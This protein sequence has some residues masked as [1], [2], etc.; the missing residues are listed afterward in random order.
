MCCI[1]RRQETEIAVDK[2]G[3][4]LSESRG[5]QTI[6]NTDYR[7]EG[8]YRLQETKLREVQTVVDRAKRHM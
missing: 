1:K 5:I 4:K 3:Y 2:R 8:A 6:R 7:E